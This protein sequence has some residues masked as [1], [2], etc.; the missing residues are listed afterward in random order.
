MCPAKADINS[1]SQISLFLCKPVGF[2]PLWAAFQHQAAALASKELDSMTRNMS[3]PMCTDTKQISFLFKQNRLAGKP[4]G[5]DGA[6]CYS[7]L[8]TA[9]KDLNPFIPKLIIQQSNDFSRYKT[10]PEAIY[11]LLDTHKQ[12]LMISMA[13]CYFLHP[14]HFSSVKRSYLRGQ[15]SVTKGSISHRFLQ[16]EMHLYEDL[17]LYPDISLESHLQMLLGNTFS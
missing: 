8:G 9:A 10:V 17:A 16:H 14:L 11:L 6:I 7:M 5:T 3:M 15:Q 2:F 4:V 1:H 12:S 13:Y